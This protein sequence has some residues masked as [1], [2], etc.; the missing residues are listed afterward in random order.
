MCPRQPVRRPSPH[1]RRPLSAAA[2]ARRAARSPGGGVRSQP[3][4]FARAGRGAR[5]RA[6]R[7]SDLRS[8]IRRR[9]HREEDARH[10]GDAVLHRLDD[11]GVH[12]DARRD[13]GGRGA[14][15]VGRSGREVSARVQARGAEQ[16]SERSRHASRRPEPPH[17][18]H[19]HGLSRNQHRTVVGRDSAPGIVRR[20]PCAV[21][22][23][24]PLQQR[25][26]PRGG[27]GRGRC[28]RHVLARAHEGAHPRSARDDGDADVVAGG[29][30]RST[31][32][33]GLPV[34]RGGSEGPAA[35][36]RDGDQHRRHRAGRCDQLHGPR[37]DRVASFPAAPGCPGRQSAHQ[38]CCPHDHLDAA[39]SDRRHGWL[40]HGVVRAQLAGTAADRAR[41][42]DHGIQRR[43]RS[44]A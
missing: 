30:E 15:A 13:A 7:G 38:S 14:H 43:C 9:G 5:D 12:R 25:A 17:R 32:G 34:G 39:D 16:G 27:I 1:R 2:A 18:L 40:R 29:V 3:H 44:A 33:P 23:A 8:R 28:G 4:R 41:R 37:H 19:P 6:R 42:R 11:E 35:D 21:P 31:H 20:S 22:A 24:I 36:A 10:A 26:L